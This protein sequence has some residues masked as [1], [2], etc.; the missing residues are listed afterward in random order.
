MELTHKQKLRLLNIARTTIE[1]Y[2]KND[3]K[4]DFNVKDGELKKEKGVFVTIHK[5]GQLRGCIG[6]IFPQD[7]LYKSVRDMAIQSSIKDPRFPPVRPEEIAGLKIEIS[8]LSVPK[9]IKTAGEIK[10]GRDGVIVKRGLRQGV[11]LPQVA[12]ETGWSK[13]KFFN[14]LCSQKAGLPEE[15]WKDEKTDLLVFQAEVFSENEM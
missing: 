10:L 2:I 13:E 4:T 5:D 7:K 6:S 11:Y 3:K 1:E 9:K 14:S 12:N 15:A 8:V